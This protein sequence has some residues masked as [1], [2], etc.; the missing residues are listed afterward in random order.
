[1]N[2][3]KQL[4]KKQ[5]AVLDDLFRGE[6]EEQAILEKHKVKMAVYDRWHANGFFAAEFARRIEALNRQSELIIAK[7]R[8]LAAAKL[9]QLTGSD[10]EETAR[11]ACLDIISLPTLSN[12]K[13]EQ[14][15]GVQKDGEKSL[16]Q[17]P[18]ETANKLLA[19]LAESQEL[20]PFENEG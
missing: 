16:P 11:K 19:V 20:V 13:P 3:K 12:E 17:L 6:L 9:V 18:P 4:Q 5:R 14:P 2:R 8:A 1:M 15:T 10:K 7:Y